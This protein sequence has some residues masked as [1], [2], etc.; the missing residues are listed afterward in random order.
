[1]NLHNCNRSYGYKIVGRIKVKTKGE[2]M[3]KQLREVDN[4]RNNQQNRTTN[5]KPLAIP[6]PSP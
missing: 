4:F 5:L 1:M 3:Q 6:L 2:G